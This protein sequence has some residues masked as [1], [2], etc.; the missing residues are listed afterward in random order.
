MGLLGSYFMY[1]PF[2]L[3]VTYSGNSHGLA[4]PIFGAGNIPSSFQHSRVLIYFVCW[5]VSHLARHWRFPLFFCS[6]S[7]VHSSGLNIYPLVALPLAYIRPLS[8]I[9]ELQKKYFPLH[10]ALCVS[11]HKIRIGELQ[12]RWGRGQKHS[13]CRNPE[14]I[15]FFEQCVVIVFKD[16]LEEWTSR[17]LQYSQFVIHEPSLHGLKASQAEEM[18]LKEFLERSQTEYSS[19]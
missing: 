11:S 16:C 10:T 4:T 15:N 1:S 7:L 9:P 2:N 19:E 17:W 12:A 8:C 14:D 13:W 6:I 5:R 18:V 3:R